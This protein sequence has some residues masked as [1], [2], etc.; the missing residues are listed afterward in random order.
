[1]LNDEQYSAYLAKRSRLGSV[2]RNL[3][4]YPKLCRYLKGDVLDIGCG[5]GDMLQ[6]R[7]HTIGVDINPFNIA[8][9][10]K[11]GLDA[12]V[13]QIDILP[14][15]DQSFDCALLDNVL[16]HIQKPENLLKEVY[17]VLRPRGKLLVGVPGIKGQQSDPDHKI[18]YDENTLILLARRHQFL[19]TEQFHMPLFKS[20][21]LSKSLSQ[22]C[23]YS[24]WKKD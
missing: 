11:R 22:Y 14:F 4:L 9:C 19:V 21:W 15:Q 2:Y 24:V 5:I 16:E 20:S 12:R 1:M 18:F 23:V 7:P 10:D 17:R 8:I 13:M 6:Y 3:V